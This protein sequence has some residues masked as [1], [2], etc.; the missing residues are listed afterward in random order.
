VDL[1]LRVPKAAIVLLVVIAAL[2]TVGRIAGN[3]ALPA[4][5]PALSAEA[6]VLVEV[7]SG[8]ILT[9][10][11]AEKVLSP[12]SLTKMMTEYLVLEAVERGDLAWD[13]VAVIR[14]RVGEATLFR[15]M[16]A[17]Q[18]HGKA[19]AKIFFRPAGNSRILWN[20]RS[21]L[22]TLSSL[23]QS[24]SLKPAGSGFVALKT[25]GFWGVMAQLE[26]VP[27]RMGVVVA[28]HAGYV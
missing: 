15:P 20:N 16:P 24:R 7:Q 13:T 4:S 2:S 28:S 21:C 5:I 19:R 18:Y 27:R 1:L 23:Q 26:A 12:A 17:F 3:S 11:N 8:R 10:K 6:A 25:G 9:R 14:P 22:H